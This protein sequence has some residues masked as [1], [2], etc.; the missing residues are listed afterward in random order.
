MVLLFSHRLKWLPNSI[1]GLRSLASLQVWTQTVLV[2]LLWRISNSLAGAVECFRSSAWIVG[3]VAKPHF[4]EFA[5]QQVSKLT[6][7]FGFYAWCP[8]PL[9]CVYFYRLVEL[10]DSLCGLISLIT[11]RCHQNR[12]HRLPSKLG[13]LRFLQYLDVAHNDLHTLPKSMERLAALTVY[14]KACILVYVLCAH[15]WVSS[16]CDCL[17]TRSLLPCS[18]WLLEACM[19]PLTERIIWGLYSNW[20]TGAKITDYLPFL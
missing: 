18:I 5:A 8:P 1:G 9:L 20:C 15:V 14:W 10:P 7:V 4:V 19:Y 11:I 16:I 6:I 13:A 12:L 2:A 17:R 3:T